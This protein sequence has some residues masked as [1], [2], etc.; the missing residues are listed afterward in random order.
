MLP[1]DINVSSHL[2]PTSTTISMTHVTLMRRAERQFVSH[3]ILVF[4]RKAILSDLMDFHSVHILAKVT[5]DRSGRICLSWK[6]LLIKVEWPFCFFTK[7]D[8]L[9]NNS[10]YYYRL[11]EQ[12]NVVR[13]VCQSFCPQSASW[14]LG[15]CSSLLRPG[16]ASTHPT[17][18]LSS[19]ELKFVRDQLPWTRNFSLQRN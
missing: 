16:R 3:C 11:Q 6:T 18:M 4:P 7:K 15:H 17:G 8:H 12:S 5:C 19:S 14:L 13:A 9:Y 10:Y 2:I 1:A